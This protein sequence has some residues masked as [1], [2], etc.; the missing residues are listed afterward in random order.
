M[1]EQILLKTMLR[2]IE[3]EEVV[4][5][6]QHG[7]TKGK[8]NQTNLVTVYDT[9]IALVE[10]GRATD[11]TCAKHLMPWIWWVDHLVGKKTVWMVTLY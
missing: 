7:F 1:K 9:I 11:V 3:N 8:L 2:Y 6:H 4:G 10:N 5:D